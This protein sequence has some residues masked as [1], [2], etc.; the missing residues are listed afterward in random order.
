MGL[1]ISKIRKAL[2]KVHK[3]LGGPL[4]QSKP[5]KYGSAQHGDS[6]KGYRLDYEK[7]PNSTNPNEQGPHINYWDYTKGKRGR[8]GIKDAE[9]IKGGVV[10]FLGS[11]LDPFDAISGELGNGDLPDHL[12]YPD[13]GDPC[14]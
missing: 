4:P 9:L 11:L 7:H 14:N 5:G 2:E 12:R 8:G 3:K 1:P 13:M 6:K 10:G